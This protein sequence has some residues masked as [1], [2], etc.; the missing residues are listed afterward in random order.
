MK[1]YTIPPP[2]ALSEFVRFFWILESNDCGYIHRSMA[3]VCPEMVFHYRG[4]FN[5]IRQE[6]SEPTSFSVVQGPLT[7]IRRF[8]INKAFGIFGVY[9]YPYSIPVLF[10][11][12]ASEISNE[13]PDILTLFGSQGRVLEEKI[14]L[15]SDSTERIK[16]I[17]EFL[18]QRLKKN[19]VNES[20]ILSSIRLI[21]KGNGLTKVGEVADKYFLSQRQFERKFKEFSG[22]SPKLFS[23]IAR[24]HYA[25]N[26]FGKKNQSLTQIAYQCGYYDQS[27]FIHD[28]KEFSGFHPKH[29]FSGKAEGTEW[30]SN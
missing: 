3:D 22:L 14:M 20:A 1:Y 7:T 6:N 12:P 30:K 18:E 26:Q 9:L 24:F 5:E 25:C 15:A 11:I 17:T 23:R 21:I 16:I 27:H 28:F 4:Q 2:A 13:M 29:Y 10:G 8:Q 19:Q